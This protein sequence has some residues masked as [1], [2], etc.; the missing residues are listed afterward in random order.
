MKFQTNFPALERGIWRIWSSWLAL[1]LRAIDP[2]LSRVAFRHG[3]PWIRR[4]C[5]PKTSARPHS[6]GRSLGLQSYAAFPIC[7][8]R[9]PCIV[10]SPPIFYFIIFWRAHLNNHY[11]R[12]FSFTAMKILY[13]ILN[14]KLCIMLYLRIIQNPVTVKHTIR[15]RCIASM[16]AW[17]HFAQYTEPLNFMF[18]EKLRMLPIS[19]NRVAVALAT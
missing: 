9:L 18:T 8:E 11:V 13:S 16:G 1:F 19:C 12:F 6:A 14:I 15:P 2:C 7:R 4:R 10:V 5:T 3:S 17:K